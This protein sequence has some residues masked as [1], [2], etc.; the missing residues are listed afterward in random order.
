MEWLF[1]W[2]EIAILLFG[3]SLFHIGIAIPLRKVIPIPLKNERNNY[4]NGN[5]LDFSEK[6][7]FFFSFNFSFFFL[8]KKEEKIKT[9]PP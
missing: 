2:N 7:L 6:L 1:L 9:P 8:K 4:F 5:R 3:M